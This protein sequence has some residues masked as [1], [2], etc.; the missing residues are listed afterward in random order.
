VDPASLDFR[1]RFQAEL[2]GDPEDGPRRRQVKGA[3]WSRVRPTPVRAPRLLAWSREVGERFGLLEPQGPLRDRWAGILA[4]NEVLPT[5]SPYAANYGG[6]QFGHWAGQLGDGRAIVLGELV[7][8]DG[9]PHELQLKGAGPTPYARGGDGRAVLR[10]SIREFLCSEAMHHLGVPTTRA[11]SLVA[12]GEMVMRDL[13]YDGNARPEPGAVVCRVAPT[14]LRMGSYELF[15]SR[16]EPDVLRRL[17]DVTLARWF[18]ALGTGPEAWVRWFDGVMR[19]TATLMAHWQRVGFVHGVMNTDNLSI[20][21]VTIDY[22]PYGWLDDYDPDFTPNTT[23]AE[24]RRYRFGQQAQVAHWNLACLGE[25]LATVVADHDGLRAV[26]D[27]YPAAHAAAWG[28]MRAAKFGFAAPSPAEEG[29]AG[30]AF[31]MLR[32]SEV[33]HT[34]FFRRLAAVDPAAPDVAALADAFYSAETFARDHRD[35][36]AWLQRWAAAVGT[37]PGRRARM[38]AANPMVVPRNWLVQRVIE[39]AEEGDAAGVGH[40]LEV[41][42]RPYDARPADDEHTHKRPEWARRRAGCSMLSC[43]S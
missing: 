34:L 14:F 39:R 22:G 35:W 6:H 8:R 25:A 37:D 15:A 10:S 12:T 29:V 11:L 16:N 30:D 21:G 43:S 26:L 9:V 5:M 1:S 27:A 3:L 7:D 23:D 17:L 18:P 33:D 13:F 20:L 36:G 40:L 41:L 42:R 31:R 28:P 19:S 4:G 24:R 2:P 32:H 38:D